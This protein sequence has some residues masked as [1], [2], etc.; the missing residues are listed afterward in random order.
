MTPSEFIALATKLADSPDSGAS[1]FR[2]AVSR[3]YYGAFLTAR[4]LIEAD[5]RVKC[6]IGTV[7]A[8]EVVQRYF[9][10]CKV[11]EA[12]QLGQL[13]SNLHGYRKNAD[14]DMDDPTHEDQDEAQL[15]IRRANEIMTRLQAISTTVMKQKLK[16]GILQYRRDLNL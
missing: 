4:V 5:L 2:S 14:Y 16:A 10:G 12:I 9:M 15:C 8:H 7:S 13:L 3:A 1:G 6:K 11:P